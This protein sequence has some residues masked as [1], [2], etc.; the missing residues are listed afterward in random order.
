MPFWHFTFSNRGGE[1][2]GYT[3]VC[4]P[5]F[6]EA[7]YLWQIPPPTKGASLPPIQV[8]SRET[9]AK[10]HENKKT[11]WF[12]RNSSCDQRLKI[13]SRGNPATFRTTQFP[14]SFVVAFGRNGFIQIAFTQSNANAAFVFV[15][16]FVFLVVLCINRPFSTRFNCILYSS[17]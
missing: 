13:R 6:T 7:S 15:V 12:T 16:A 10:F 14:A 4:T 17:S 8:S 1:G 2:R 3:G 9:W 11:D 5:D